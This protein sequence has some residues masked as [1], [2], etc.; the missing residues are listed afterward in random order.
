MNSGRV[1]LA[2]DAV[3]TEEE[4]IQSFDTET[5]RKDDSKI[6]DLDRRII[7]NVN[8]PSYFLNLWEFILW[9]SACC[10]V[11]CQLLSPYVG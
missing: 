8:E 4:W 11:K 2:G 6:L 7:L 3:R 10:V 5:Q 9:P 1:R